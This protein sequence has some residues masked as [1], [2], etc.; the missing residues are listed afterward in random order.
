LTSGGIIFP[1]IVEILILEITVELIREAAIRLPTYIGTAVSVFA[2]LV[3]GQAAVEARVVSNL[4]IVIV[5]ATATASY[6]V[7]STDMAL[8]IRIIRFIFMLA[9]SMFGI[10]GIVVCTV[11]VLGH[12]IVLDSLGQPYFIPFSPFAPEGLKDSI[13]RL[14][15]KA[16]NRR[17]VETRTGKKVR[18]E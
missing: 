16:Q 5:A 7:P 4:V 18:S 14:P 3:I 12:L 15:F 11:F 10:I 1:P 6:V 17:P 13:L 8:S 9:A 2:G